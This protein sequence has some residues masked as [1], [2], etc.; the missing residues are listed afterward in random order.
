MRD[1]RPAAARGAH[2]DRWQAAFW[3]ALLTFVASLLAATLIV[4]HAGGTSASTPAAAAATDRTDTALP[5]PT[6]AAGAATTPESAT[7]TTPV[8]SPSPRATQG[9]IQGDVPS[10]PLRQ[11]DKLAAAVSGVIG[12]DPSGFGVVVKRLS[13]GRGTA[14][15]DDQVF[16]AASTFKLAILYEAERRISEGT[17]TLD[18]TLTLTEDDLKEDLGTIKDVGLGPDNTISIGDALR[19]MVTMSDNSTAVALLHLLGGAQIDATMTDLGMLH[20]DFNTE[21]L[22]TTAGDMATLM[23]A[24]YNG[25]GLSP[26]AQQHARGLLL[27]QDIR[28][29]IPQGVPN[30]VPV[31]N[32]T[33]TWDGATHDVAFVEAPSGV[34]V[35]AVLSTGSWA[36]TPLQNISAAVYAA[37]TAP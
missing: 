6:Q 24:V 20:T 4:L 26:E 33:G 11:D 17:L 2:P 25:W 12:D 16:Y 7:P 15:N 21:E 13:D 37:M 5:S 22:P 3:I 14:L 18:D 10:A 8:S 9:P 29:G 19:V 23:E 31:G 32:K 28:D 30:G 27:Q 36:W 35:I 34:Y 1:P